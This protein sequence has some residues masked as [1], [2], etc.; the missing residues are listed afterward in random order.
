MKQNYKYGFH[1]IVSDPTQPVMLLS[2]A[3]PPGRTG[4]AHL[5]AITETVIVFLLQALL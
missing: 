3:Q 5:P 2:E 1:S 4:A